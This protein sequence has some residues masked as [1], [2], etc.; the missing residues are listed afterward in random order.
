MIHSFNE[1]ARAESTMH[2]EMK[3]CSSRRGNTVVHAMF[4]RTLSPPPRK[5]L[6]KHHSS[7]LY[8]EMVMGF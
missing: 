5:Q 2:D 8:D 3:R 6:L 4:H 1:T 7:A